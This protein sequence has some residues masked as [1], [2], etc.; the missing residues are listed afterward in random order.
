MGG[1]ACSKG[2]KVGHRAVPRIPTAL[3][4]L[5]SD[6]RDTAVSRTDIRE[7]RVQRV[8][9]QDKEKEDERLLA[10]KPKE[11]VAPQGR[12]M[13]RAMMRSALRP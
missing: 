1:C 4:P 12:F 3:R 11:S 13:S 8:S 6:A 7:R 9:Q 2:G 5:H 10:T